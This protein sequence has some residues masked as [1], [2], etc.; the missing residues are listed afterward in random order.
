MIKKETSKM[1][2][3][4]EFLEWLRSVLVWVQNNKE[5]VSVSLGIIGL[6]GIVARKYKALFVTLFNEIKNLFKK[7]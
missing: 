4:V 3:I 5:N 2:L 6:L 7:K 1:S